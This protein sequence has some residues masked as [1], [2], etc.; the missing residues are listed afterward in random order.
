MPGEHRRGGVD[1]RIDDQDKADQPI[2]P[3][4]QLCRQQGAA[5]PLL[6][7][8]LQAMTVGHHHGGFGHGEE[9][10]HNQQHRQQ[11][12]LSGEREFFHHAER[13]VCKLSD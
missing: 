10:G 12:E 11:G 7:Q 5:M 9:A 13:L 6:S 2:D 8:M 1:Q 3:L 4:E